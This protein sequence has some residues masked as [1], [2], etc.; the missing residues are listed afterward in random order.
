M[1]EY[2][3][4]VARGGYFLDRV[5]P[6]WREKVTPSDI[7]M[8]GV[9]DCVIG[10][11]FGSFSSVFDYS[12]EAEAYARYLGFQATT[13]PNSPCEGECDLDSEGRAEFECYNIECA[14]LENAWRD[15]LK[16]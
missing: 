15:Y 10:Q 3:T 9:Y 4:R 14:F 16:V 11:V 5:K 12:H 1:N 13:C 8:S 7:L 2:D 6:D